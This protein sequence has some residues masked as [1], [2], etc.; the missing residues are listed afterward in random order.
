MAVLLASPLSSAL[1][2]FKVET[3]L[4]E[5]RG[6]N[7]VGMADIRHSQRTRSKQGILQNNVAKLR[8]Y[9]YRLVIYRED[10]GRFAVHRLSGLMP[11]EMT[12]SVG[13]T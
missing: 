2:P 9:G 3:G 4:V 1:E 6:N 8:E 13:P 7:L 5:A 10:K 12:R 11:F